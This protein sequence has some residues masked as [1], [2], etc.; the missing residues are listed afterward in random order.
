MQRP[1]SRFNDS[2]LLTATGQ[3]AG[4]SL[5][6]LPIVLTFEQT[7]TFSD[8]RAETVLAILA[9]ALLT[10]AAGYLIFFWL[11]VRAGATNVASTSFLVPITAL[12]LGAFVLG[13]DLSWRVFAG[14]ALIFCGLIV[15]DGRA[16]TA[17]RAAWTGQH[18]RYRG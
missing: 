3:L 13:E 2:Q 10:T 18:D 16:S 9:L 7:W 14:A 4:A 5:L 15:L 11:L 8:L 6:S 1:R 12:F 17:V